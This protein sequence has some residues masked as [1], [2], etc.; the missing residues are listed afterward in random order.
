M[1]PSVAFAIRMSWK[2]LLDKGYSVTDVARLFG[3]SRL[4]PHK[5]LAR[6]AAEGMAGLLDLSRHPYTSPTFL[7][8]HNV[9]Q[10]LQLRRLE[11]IGRSRIRLKSTTA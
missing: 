1:D 6:Y 7:P 10:I 8:I 4:T 5:W 2:Q 3:R 11:K 9:Q